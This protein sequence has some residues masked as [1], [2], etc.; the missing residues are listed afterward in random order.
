[1]IMEYSAG[2]ISEQEARE[3]LGFTGMNPDNNVYRDMAAQL[4]KGGGDEDG[5]EDNEAPADERQQRMGKGSKSIALARA[6]IELAASMKR[7][8]RLNRGD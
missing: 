7:L 3:A 6:G 8:Q 5:E 2:L 4:L 1:M